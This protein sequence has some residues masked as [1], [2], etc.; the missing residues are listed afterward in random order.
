MVSSGELKVRIEIAKI[1][2]EGLCA[3]ALLVAVLWCLVL[4]NHRLVLR[5]EADAS[6]A[7][8]EL[9]RLRPEPEA[10]PWKSHEK[11]AHSSVVP[12]SRASSVSI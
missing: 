10:G 7:M 2:N 11:S 8:Q 5:T 9:R 1:S 4:A 12:A 3:T 6:Q